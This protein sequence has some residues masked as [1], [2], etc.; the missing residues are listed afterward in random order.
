MNARWPHDGRTFPSAGDAEADELLEGLHAQPKHVSSRY[1][2][3]ERGSRLFREICRL[4]E[5]YPTRTESQILRA[6]A[7]DMAA[8]IGPG[9]LVIELGS[10]AGEKTRILLDHLDHPAGYVPVDVC[11]EQ[12]VSASHRIA[13]DYPHIPVAPLCADFTR[14][15]AVPSR[16]RKPARTAIFFPGST[17]GNFT[18]AEARALLE[19]LRR[20]AGTG[21]ALLLGVDMV[22]SPAMLHAA[23]NDAAG[24]TARFNLNILSHLNRRFGGNFDDALFTHAAPWQAEERRIEMQLWCQRSHF[25]EIAGTA[26]AFKEGEKLVTEWSHKYT[27]RSFGNLARR[28]GW[29]PQAVWCDPAQLFS[30]HYLV[31]DPAPGALARQAAT[32]A[33]LETVDAGMTAA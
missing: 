10:G 7:S 9:A 4:P 11:H 3:D 1:L 13:A 29:I 8:A 22:K 27:L 5:Y 30:V 33:R 19:N 16:F 17:I 15:L 23:Y 18:T 21:G 25:V 2:Y 32:G 24:V 12:L 28:S 26:V 6:S 14:R 20:L 31:A